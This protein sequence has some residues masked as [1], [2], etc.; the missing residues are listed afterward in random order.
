M[1]NLTR[2]HQFEDGALLGQR[3]ARARVAFDVAALKGLLSEGASYEAGDIKLGAAEIARAWEGWEEA[4]PDPDSVTIGTIFSRGQVG[5]VVCTF[6]FSADGLEVDE[7]LLLDKQLSRV[8]CIVRTAVR[9]DGSGSRGALLLQKLD[10]IARHSAATPPSGFPSSVA[11]GANTVFMDGG[12]GEDEETVNAQAQLQGL[13]VAMAAKERL[14]TALMKSKDEQLTMQLNRERVQVAKLRER[15]R[16]M[17]QEI[18]SLTEQL[19]ITLAEGHGSHAQTVGDL[20]ANLR[21]NPRLL[22][23]HREQRELLDTFTRDVNV[24]VQ[25]FGGEQLQQFDGLK[26][27]INSGL[28][29]LLMAIPA[30]PEGGQRSSA[31][32]MLARGSKHRVSDGS[33]RTPDGLRS[34]GRGSAGASLHKQPS[35]AGC[36]TPPS[37]AEATPAQ[38]PLPSG[39][40]PWW[41]AQRESV[42][43][44]ENP[45]SAGGSAAGSTLD[46][47]EQRAATPAPH[48]AQDLDRSEFAVADFAPR[49]KPPPLSPNASSAGASA[50]PGTPRSAAAAVEAAAEGAPGTLAD[51]LRAVAALLRRGAD[52]G[53][54]DAKRAAACAELLQG[55]SVSPALRSSLGLDAPAPLGEEAPAPAAPLAPPGPPTRKRSGGR[56][57]STVKATPP[58]SPQG[59]GGER[60]GP[61]TGHPRK[62]AQ[63]AASG[64]TRGTQTGPFDDESAEGKELPELPELQKTAPLAPHAPV[65]TPVAAAVPLPAGRSDGA[66][67]APAAAPLPRRPSEP[68][69][70]PDPAS[71]GT[72]VLGASAPLPEAEPR[73]L[74]GAGLLPTQASGTQCAQCAKL[75]LSAPGPLPRPPQKQGNLASSAGNIR[76]S[77]W[78]GSIEEAPAAPPRGGAVLSPRHGGPPSQRDQLPLH[79]RPL[80]FDPDGGNTPV[81]RCGAGS[82][83]QQRMWMAAV[84]RAPQGRRHGAGRR[85]SEA[86]ADAEALPDIGGDARGDLRRR[87][88]GDE[89]AAKARAAWASL[90]AGSGAVCVAALQRMPQMY[91]VPGGP[92]RQAAAARALLGRMQWRDPRNISYAEFSSFYEQL[93]H[94]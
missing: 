54:T 91:S 66:D 58:S 2:E 35:S 8:R 43:T 4:L 93:A 60:A 7:K 70:A 55:G 88:S 41:A 25:T 74:C 22:K 5:V 79:T 83:K 12:L 38:P 53:G 52:S 1:S 77:R 37:N 27:S 61:R 23:L 39:A 51:L 20:L 30:L 94:L 65:Q 18:E 56:M 32:A 6:C 76:G 89:H 33:T 10:D 85:G 36:G 78:R 19:R 50:A 63:T 92:T 17:A 80:A 45:P 49:R 34:P 42:D 64:V 82:R 26:E 46:A 40:Q 13:R 90:S 72:A 28:S 57:A 86:E 84:T 71:F 67:P 11:D 87:S 9:H 48:P 15:I 81:A 68:P 44:R 16:Q 24:V 31:A 3:Y 62:R 73:C 21:N 75:T 47:K 14:W 69:P 59:A 29:Q